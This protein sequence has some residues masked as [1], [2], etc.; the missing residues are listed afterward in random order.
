MG[1]IADI[2]LE[3]ILDA[4]GEYTG[5]NPG[6][7]IYPKGWFKKEFKSSAPAVNRVKN[8]LTQRGIPLGDEQKSLLKEYGSHVNTDRPTN[9]AN[10]N[11]K[12]FKSFV[13]EKVGYVKPSKR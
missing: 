4:N 8:F 11:W 13:D 3:G 1:E 9:H 5:I 7:P 2:M 12:V 6:H 10:S